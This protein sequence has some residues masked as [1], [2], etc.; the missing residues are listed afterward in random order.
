MYIISV[1]TRAGKKFV[2]PFGNLTKSRNKAAKFSNEEEA[3]DALRPENL[4]H[5]I[6]GWEVIEV[7]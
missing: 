6:H 2:A 7:A 5:R 1:D 4:P 3:S